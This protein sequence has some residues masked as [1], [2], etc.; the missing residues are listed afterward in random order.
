MARSSLPK[1]S[2]APQ[3]QTHLSVYPNLLGICH[4]GISKARIFCRAFAHG[5]AHLSLPALLR[6]GI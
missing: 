3:G 5:N 2:L 4:S 1:V 6:T